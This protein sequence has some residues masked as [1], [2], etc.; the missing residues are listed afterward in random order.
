MRKINKVV[1]LYVI[2]LSAVLA[3]PALTIP[4]VDH[5]A[6]QEWENRKL[7][8]RPKPAEVITKPKQAFA[9]L[10]DYVDDHIGGGFQVIKA[11]RKFYFEAFGATNDIYIAGNNQ[12]AYFLTSPFR[13][14]TRERPF[15]WWLNICVNGQNPNYQKSYVERFNKSHDFLARYG[16]N[17][18][19]GMVPSKSVLMADKLPKST[20]YKII[21]ACKK[22]SA[23][24]NLAKTLSQSAP[25]LNFFYPYEAFKARIEDPL[26]YPSKAYHWQGESSWIFAEE[27]AK[28]YDLDVSPKWQ[29]SDCKN[30]QVEWDIG[31]LIGVG[32]TTLGCDRDR[33]AL[34]IVVDASFAYPLNEGADKDEVIVAKMTNLNAPND[35]TAIVFS[36]SFG[37]VVREL[38]ASHFQTTYHL[39]SSFINGPDMQKLLAQS[40]ILKADDIFITVADFHYPGFLDWVSPADKTKQIYNE[41]AVAAAKAREKARQVKKEAIEKRREE[42]QEITAQKEAEKQARIEALE[43]RR[44]EQQ[45][46][47]VQKEAEKEARIE[48]L[49]KRRAE[50]QEILA[51][52][53]AEKQDRIEALEKRRAE[54]QKIL[55]Q[56]EAEK[57]ARI[58][59][60]EKK[61]AQ[62]NS[63][64]SQKEPP[65]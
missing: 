11:R 35:K 10:D 1:L 28:A 46:I 19:Y 7:T 47:M 4:M 30:T 56:K 22:I 63:K 54:Q 62:Q 5:D 36:N 18:V 59:A 50:Q 60:L 23:E 27:L 14:K 12:G 45:A 33:E 41:D 52:K 65:K 57:E 64:D 8:K 53:E 25:N 20:P 32:E 21:E 61:R 40:E 49:E 24:N 34:G 9:Q 44:A 2:I 16:A 51:Q 55:A 58:E 26:F 39:R 38:I 3:I 6:R 29:E 13:Q 31:M 15:S 42:Q 37:P 17:V 43:K 48:A